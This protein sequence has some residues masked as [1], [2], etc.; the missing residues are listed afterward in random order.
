[1]YKI[2]LLVWGI[3]CLISVHGQ[4]AQQ[5]NNTN[6]SE[7]VKESW[8]NIYQKRDNGKIGYVH[9][10]IIDKI[11]NATKRLSQRKQIEIIYIYRLPQK[12]YV[13][14]IEVTEYMDGELLL[15]SKKFV[16]YRDKKEVRETVAKQKQI[17]FFYNGAK[18]KKVIKPLKTYGNFGGRIIKQENKLFVGAKGQ[19]Y[20]AQ[21]EKIELVNFKVTALKNIELPIGNFFAYEVNFS[22]ISDDFSGTIHIGINGHDLIFEMEK[23]S[24][25]WKMTTE[26]D[27][28]KPP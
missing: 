4:K 27:A 3:S 16:K 9:H 5:T 21:D 1:M 28:E 17:E 11:D 14:F 19:V 23:P 26:E 6:K 8:Y 20:M 25:V 7:Q 15:Q 2:I 13:K 18:T 22:T 12:K 24:L 10:K